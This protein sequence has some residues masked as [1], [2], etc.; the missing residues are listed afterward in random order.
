MNLVLAAV[1]SW[2]IA[3]LLVTLS[4]VSL[5]I[6]RPDLP[7]AFRSPFFPIPQIISS[8]GIILGIRYITPPGMNSRDVYLPFLAMLGVVAFYALIWS[9]FKMKANP[10]KPVAVEEIL[11]KEFAK[12]QTAAA[13]PRGDGCS[14]S[15]SVG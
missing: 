9:A 5:R 4:V 11:Q 14:S 3:Y 15:S 10:F 8:A 2:G 6:R 1:C 13:E 7:R 12:Q